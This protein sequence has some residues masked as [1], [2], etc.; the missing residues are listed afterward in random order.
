[1]SKRQGKGMQI[2]SITV[3]VSATKQD[4]ITIYEHDEASQVCRDFAFKHNLPQNLELALTRSVSS[5]MQEIAQEQLLLSTSFSS[6][7]LQAPLNYKN[8]GEKLYAKGLKHKEQI[9]ANNQLLKIQQEKK[10]AEKTTFHPVISTKSKKLA[11]NIQSRSESDLK[12]SINTTHNSEAE[13]TFAPK[14]NE[15]SL[16]LAGKT[17]NRVQELYEDAKLKKLRIEEMNLNARK[18]EFPFRP[19]AASRTEFPDPMEVVTRLVDDKRFSDIEELRKKYEV[20]RDP[21]TGQV[22]F[23]PNI[24]KSNKFERMTEDVWDSL[25]KQQKK[26]FG[27][28]QEY[29]HYPVDMKSKEMNERIILKLKLDRYLEVFSMLR[30]DENGLICYGN[31]QFNEVDPKILKAIMPLLEELKEIDQPLNFEEFADSMDRLVKTLSH[32]E[33]DL[34]ILKPKQKNNKNEINTKKSHSLSDCTALY[35]RNVDKKIK[36]DEKLQIERE[37]LKIVELQGCTFKPK[38]TKF[39]TKVFK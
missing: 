21:K 12:K 35:L 27:E 8:I 22:F 5:M 37:K 10:A 15:K 39:P 34:F 13:Y 19:N 33:K 38:T 14:I 2:L 1:M 29:P 16:K 7:S 4:Q 36:V 25:Y 31:I 6:K 18:N 30:P 28:M 32:E 20:D 23:I 11:R 3:D 26:N 24:G 17:E 9:E